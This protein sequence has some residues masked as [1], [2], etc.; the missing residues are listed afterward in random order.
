MKL[1]E[2]PAGTFLIRFSEGELGAVTIA[3][4]TERSGTKEILMLQPWSSKDFSIRGLADRIFDLPE[5]THLFPDIPKELAFGLFRTPDIPQE[6]G[7]SGYVPSGIVARIKLTSS[8]SVSECGG[9]SAMDCALM[10]APNIFQDNMDD[11]VQDWS[12]ILLDNAAPLDFPI[13]G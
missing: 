13:T 2:R 1:L 3:W 9:D 7:G 11:N 6:S 10:N 4:C 12:G 8:D 5:L